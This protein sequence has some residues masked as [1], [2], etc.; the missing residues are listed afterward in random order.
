MSD[1]LLEHVTRSI[2]AGSKSFAAAS[3]LFAPDVRRGALMLY[4]WCRH[5]DDVIDGQVSGMTSIEAPPAG[6]TSVS[7]LNPAPEARL[8]SLVAATQA[9]YAGQPMA[10]P[11]FAA[12]QEVATD[13]SIPSAYAFEHLAGFEMDVMGHHYETID[14]TMTYCYRVAGVVGLMMARIM[15]VQDERTLDRACDLGLAFQLTNIAR[16]IAEDA[17]LGRCYVPAAWLRDAGVTRAD[18]I[19]P[20]HTHALSSLAVRLVDYAEPYYRSADAG[21][22]ALPWRSAWAVAAASNVYREIGIKL[23]A[24]APRDVTVRMST[25]RLDKLRLISTAAGSTLASRVQSATPRPAGLWDRPAVPDSTNRRA[26]PAS[27][28]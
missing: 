20:E 9:A 15:G 17:R 12:F 16:D 10:E 8:A 13:Y 7:G 26:S 11:A 6:G 21:I 4:A 2:E 5:C 3:R 18:M 22:P 1:V 14:D 27:V 25:T 24:R 28:A 23:K 19:R